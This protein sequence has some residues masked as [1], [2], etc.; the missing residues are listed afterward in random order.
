[1]LLE[2]VSPVARHR[3]AFGLTLSSLSSVVYATLTGRDYGS[4]RPMQH[5]LAD[6]HLAT[7]CDRRV[8]S[9]DH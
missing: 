5:A 3:L 6:S 2:P 7:V 9:A 4:G 1:M 8:P